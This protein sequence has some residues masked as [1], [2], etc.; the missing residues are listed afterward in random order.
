[1]EDFFRPKIVWGEISDKSKFAYDSDS[2]YTEATT[3][4]MTGNNLKYLLAMLNSKLLEWYFNQIGTATGVGTNRWKKYTI[5]LL[6][7]VVP[8]K[9]TIEI[10]EDHINLIITNKNFGKS[11]EEILNNIIFELYGLSEEESLYI[12]N[13]SI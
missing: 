8:N 7:I 11:I 3:F 5:E 10:I 12:N 2:I 13:T 1:M 6:P 4:L 9:E